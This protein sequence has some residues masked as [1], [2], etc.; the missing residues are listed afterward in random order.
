MSL[1]RSHLL[2]CVAEHY[3]GGLLKHSS[4]HYLSQAVILAQYTHVWQTSVRRMAACQIAN[5]VM[6]D[7]RKSAFGTG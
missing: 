6:S 4:G 7:Q 1:P 2:L 3:L 5:L